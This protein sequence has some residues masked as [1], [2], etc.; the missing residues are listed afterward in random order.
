M[1]T[2]SGKQIQAFYNECL[3][4]HLDYLEDRFSPYNPNVLFLQWRELIRMI[5][6]LINI[7]LELD[8]SG[9]VDDYL[10]LKLDIPNE[11]D[12][13]DLSDVCD[14][15]QTKFG[16]RTR[17]RLCDFLLMIRAINISYK[18]SQAAFILNGFDLSTVGGAIAYFQSRRVY[19]VT[20]LGLIPV[21]SCGE[22][23]LDFKDLL[24]IF[25]YTIESC[26]I[27]ITNSYYG[28]LVSESILDYEVY[29]DDQ[30]VSSNFEYSV[31]EDFFLEPQRL[32]LLD[33]LNYCSAEKKFMSN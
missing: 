30:T 11:K 8:D 12:I 22:K 7:P 2:I 19:Y 3:Q 31:L 10:N 20:I 32:S 25:H 27:N 6:E 4:E 28:L 1:R 15:I 26:A 16:D 21:I 23:E 9:S 18:V 24:N 17:R 33:Q 13:K 5:D 14:F 29:I